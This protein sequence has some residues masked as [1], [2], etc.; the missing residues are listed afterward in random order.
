M[1]YNNK[2]NLY[3]VL[4]KISIILTILFSGWLVWE[5]VSNRPLG[6][7]EYSA[8]NKAFKDSNYELAYKYYKNA[9]KVNPNDVYVIEGI[10][11]SLM[12]LK[13]YNEAISYF[14]LAIE[15]Q[16]NFAPAHANLGVLYD[17]MG[18]HEKAI[19]LYS[20]AL[21]L[22]SDLEK[23]MHW[24]DRLLYNV[25]E[26]PPTVKDRLKYLQNQYLLNENER[27]LS[28]PEV[29]DKQLNYEK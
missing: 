11:R 14:I 3:S 24:I 13:N 7:N 12:E 4:V 21:R 16:P 26:V 29:D 1:A 23:G 17:R 19:E 15:S 10:A 28:V 18:D 5:H 8:A 25:Q 20:E 22:D 27:I 2:D 6:T 9:Y